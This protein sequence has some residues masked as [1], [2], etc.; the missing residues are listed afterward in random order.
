MTSCD[1]F[2]TGS[3]ATPGGCHTVRSFLD[4]VKDLGQ[5]KV[6]KCRSA[7]DRACVQNWIDWVGAT[8]ARTLPHYIYLPKNI[9]S[10]LLKYWTEEELQ[11]GAIIATMDGDFALIRAKHVDID[12]T[13][14]SGRKLL[15]YVK[16][17]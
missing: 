10:E 1:I 4:A 8:E 14:A 7:K 9:Q 17:L 15:N 12:R 3:G 6:K 2:Y 16:K 11:E 13:S 5:G